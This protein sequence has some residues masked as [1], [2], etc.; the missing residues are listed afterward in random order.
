LFSKKTWLAI[1]FF[2][3]AVLVLTR[4]DWIINTVLYK[5]GLQFSYGW[6]REYT[7]LY[8][9]LFQLVIL[10]LSVWIQN[11]YFLG[12]TEAFVLSGTQDLI[13]FGLWCGY[14]PSENW[15]WMVFYEWFGSWTTANQ[16]ALCLLVNGLVFGFCT[17][18]WLLWN[19]KLKTV[20]V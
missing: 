20:E 7:L 19:H 16:F 5:Y 9:L 3:G 6:Y 15:T 11:W 12:L 2:F 18:Q 1:L 8:M 13:Y 14:F 10:P 4:V 17:F